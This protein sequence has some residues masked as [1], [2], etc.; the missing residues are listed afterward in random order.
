MGEGG[1]KAVS[2]KLPVNKQANIMTATGDENLEDIFHT[3][4]TTKTPVSLSFYN[5]FLFL[6]ETSFSI[7]RQ[8]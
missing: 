2:R 7:H 4:R 8:R 5:L 3:I 1:E 6:K